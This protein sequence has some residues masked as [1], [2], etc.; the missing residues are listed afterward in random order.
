MDDDK[1]KKLM[2]FF[3][4]MAD[5]SS[6]E[7]N[8]AQQRA[9]ADEL[10]KF[11]TSSGARNWAGA[12][13]RGLQGYQAGAADR[14]A[15]AAYGDPSQPVAGQTGTYLFNKKNQLDALMKLYQ[16]SAATQAAAMPQSNVIQ[17]PQDDDYG[18]NPPPIKRPED[19]YGFD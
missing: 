7:Q 11:A 18:F 1:D 8:I 15:Q 2:Q 4:T 12:L 3:A 19:Y 9:R 16:N 6:Q 13:A 14:A 10:R 5:L 17:Q